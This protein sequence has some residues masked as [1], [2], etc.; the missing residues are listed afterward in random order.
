MYSLRTTICLIRQLC[1][2]ILLNMIVSALLESRSFQLALCKPELCV[3]LVK[4]KD[5]PM[6]ATKTSRYQT[7][8]LHVVA[9]NVS[10]LHEGVYEHVIV[11][12]LC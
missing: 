6:S 9:G 2:D 8:L 10:R 3:A 1:I 11:V 4:T 7:P 5:L 12:V